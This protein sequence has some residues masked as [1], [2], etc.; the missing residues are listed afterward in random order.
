MALSKEPPRGQ[1]LPSTLGLMWPAGRG[2]AS[3]LTGPGTVC[4]CLGMISDEGA[5]LGFPEQ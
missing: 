2:V 3:G 4:S 1:L 5:G